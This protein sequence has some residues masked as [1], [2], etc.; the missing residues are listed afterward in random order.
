MECSTGAKEV[1][2][3]D[4]EPLA[5]QC[6]LKSASASGVANVANFQATSLTKDSSRVQAGRLPPNIMHILSLLCMC[7]LTTKTT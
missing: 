5:L 2:M 1:V 6:A 4:R 7:S 3:T